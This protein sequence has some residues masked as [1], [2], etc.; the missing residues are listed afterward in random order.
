MIKKILAAVILSASLLCA[1][2]TPEHHVHYGGAVLTVGGVQYFGAY[3][4]LDVDVDI[5]MAGVPGTLTIISF[6]SLNGIYPVM[7]S[8]NFLV[9][10]STTNGHAIYS[11]SNVKL[12]LVPVNGQLRQW[13]ATQ[14]GGSATVAV[15]I[16]QPTP[17]D[18]EENNDLIIVLTK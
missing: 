15:G 16:Q 4:L 10:S 3:K 8:G 9:S 5:T 13:L 2:Y 1:Q 6:A 11:W 7:Q 12:E 14:S 18:D 17:D